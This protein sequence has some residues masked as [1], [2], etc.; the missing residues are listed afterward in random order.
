MSILFLASATISLCIASVHDGDT[1]RLCNGERVRLANIDAPE[2]AG[3]SRCSA[4]SKAHLSASTNPS[5]CDFNAG[6]QSRDQLRAF[7]SVGTP[8]IHR[9]GM[10]HGRT[11]ATLS[12][13]GKDAGEYLITRGLARRW[14]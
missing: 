1:I 10:D 3:S 5:W 2:L 13:H 9:S 4:K 8:V 7:L 6:I 12:V 14:R 11:L